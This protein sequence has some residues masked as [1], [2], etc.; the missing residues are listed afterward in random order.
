MAITTAIGDLF[1]SFYEIIASIFGAAYNVVHAVISVIVGFFSG[2]FNLIAGVI[3]ET[4]HAT[5]STGKFI[6]HNADKGIWIL[7]GVGAAVL[8]SRYTAQGQ[9][10]SNK[11]LKA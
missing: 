5:G 3:K 9:R 10:A 4:L 11:S 2:I 7:V 1:S 6:L 8:L